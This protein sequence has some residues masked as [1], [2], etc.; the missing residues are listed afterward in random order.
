MYND[1]FPQNIAQLMSNILKKTTIA[2]VKNNYFFV[3]RSLSVWK[4]RLKV[5]PIS[6][7]NPETGPISAF[8]VKGIKP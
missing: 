2:S 1:S 8:Q 4:R 5:K 3:Q 7:I 6:R